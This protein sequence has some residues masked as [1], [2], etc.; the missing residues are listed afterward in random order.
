MDFNLIISAQTLKLAPELQTSDL[1]NGIVVLKNVP[2]KTYLK[3]TV[4]QWIILKLF[5]Q[6]RNV[7]SILDHAIRER[8]CIP[9][10][11]FYELI[12]KAVR[13]HILVE[14]G[15]QPPTIKACDWRVPVRAHRVARPIGVLF[16]AGLVMAFGFRPELPSSVLDVL[17]GLVIL[18]AACSCATLLVGCVIRGADG[19]VYHP[20]WEWLAVPP[21]FKVDTSDMGMLPRKVQDMIFTISPAML[22]AATG[23]TT[24][25]RPEWAFVPLLGL[26]A[27]LRP[28]LGGEF[29]SVIRLGAVDEQSDAEHNFIFP[30]NQGPP[31]RW[32]MLRRALR[33]RNTWVTNAYAVIWTLALIY[34]GARLTDT[35]PWTYEFWET[36]GFRVVAAISA[37]LAVL[38]VGYFCWEFYLLFRARATAWRFGYR[39]WHRRWFGGKKLVLDETERLEA[40]V[41]SPLLRLLNPP[42]RQQMVQAMQVARHGP[43]RALAQYEGT[44]PT[45]VALIVSGRIALRRT[46]PSGRK[47]RVQILQAGDVIGLHDLADPAHP[48]YAI[49]T[50]T[51]VTLLTV[52]RARAEEIFNGRLP[53]TT[54]TN[55]LLKLPFLRS[56]SLCANWHVQAVERFAVLSTVVDCPDDYII[57]N[58]GMFVDRFF[59]IFEG[60][61]IVTREHKK[62]AILQAGEF[63]GEIGLLQN[64]T[65]SATITAMKGTR[66]L[67]IVRKE[68]LRF[69]THNFSV[70]LELERVSSRRLRRPIFPLRPGDFRPT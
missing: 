18:S 48:N 10:G 20:R 1:G 5:E 16:C 39:Q 40:I 42:Q 57:F 59:I 33:L 52:P 11:E 12:L 64:S 65:A 54:F 21:Q 62:L 47:V 4:P 9:L 60:A 55:I 23:V 7:P 50:M 35:P 53:P 30:P 67:A 14:P 43:W 15:I 31:A 68:F 70:A 22:A 27:S 17:A 3:V 32:R 46:L 6:P 63:F 38:A 25:Y 19:E 2:A 56:S 45:E 37:S 13:T 29:A 44:P 8:L 36:H 66:C 69:V 58:E 51:P 34:L 26:M 61:A 41:G 49:R 24:W 28:V